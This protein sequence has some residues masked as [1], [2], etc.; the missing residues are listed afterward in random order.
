MHFDDR[1]ATVLRQRAG[2][3]V[4]ARIQY[5]QLL[6]LLGTM[7]VAAQGEAADAASLRMT[8]LAGEIDAPARVAMLREPG[9]RL[10]NPQ[11][12]AQLAGGEPQV[13]AAAL[14]AAQLLEEQWLDLAPALPVA[15]RAYLGQ[16]RDL[17]PKVDGLLGRLGIFDRGLP[18]AQ[19]QAVRTKRKKSSEDTGQPSKADPQT[20]GALVRRIDEFRKSRQSIEGEFATSDAPRLPLDDEVGGQPGKL[21]AAFDFTTDAQLKIDWCSHDMAP[22]AVGLRLAFAP[23]RHQPVRAARIG[24]EG[25][26]AIA[27][28]WQ[29]DASPRF[30]P[31]DGHFTGYAGRMRRL[32]GITAPSVPAQATDDDADRMRQLLHELRTPVN[33]IQGFAE[34]IQQQL[35]GPTP[36]GYRALAA[37]VASDAAS[38]LAGFEELERLSQLEAG[39]MELDAG[40]CDFA[41]ILQAAVARLA[42]FTDAR[43]SGFAVKL[44]GALIAA[45]AKPDAEQLAWRLLA[46]LAGAANPGEVLSLTGNHSGSTIFV[47]L[48][49]PLA[50]KGDGPISALV[51]PANSALS[52]GSFGTGFALRLAA[53]EARAAGGSLERRGQAMEL[54]LPDLTGKAAGHSDEAASQ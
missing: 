17:G 6:D 10:R 46:A 12:V 27:G 16:R 32:A 22:M 49:M 34:V 44:D 19:G 35:F 11:F 39:N 20:I 2:G 8:E 37:S 24:I 45:L 33:A 4:A 53:A 43:S 23:D 50:L 21:V 18:P 9:V 14:E 52:P 36:H 30:D 51:A 1:L 5:R 41:E 13:A 42:H 38:I 29:V 15:A 28:S 31:V 40:S 7:P 3:E 25:A 47:K 26:P 54:C 48:D